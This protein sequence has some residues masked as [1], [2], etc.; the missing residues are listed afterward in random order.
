LSG[1]GALCGWSRLMTL[2]N[3]IMVNAIS[4]SWGLL[5]SASLFYISGSSVL[6]CAVKPSDSVWQ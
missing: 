5:I 6:S 3:S 4:F 2:F 1:P